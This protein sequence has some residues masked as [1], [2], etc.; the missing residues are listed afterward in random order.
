[1]AST[2]IINVGVSSGDE[3][4]VT[5]AEDVTSGVITG[6]SS[7]VTIGDAG[8]A[9]LYLNSVPIYYRP[10]TEGAASDNSYVRIGIKAGDVVA[11]EALDATIYFNVTAA[12]SAP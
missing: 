5:I 1:M 8:G 2:S 9:L 10:F 7:V 6:I 12:I 11:V 4:E 3:Y